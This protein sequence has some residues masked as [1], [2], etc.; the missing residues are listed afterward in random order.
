[1]IVIT[2]SWPFIMGSVNYE[3]GSVNVVAFGNCFKKLRIMDNSFFHEPNNNIL[4][5]SSHFSEIIALNSEFI[6]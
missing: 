3:V 4:T 1:M 6:F 2:L 5:G